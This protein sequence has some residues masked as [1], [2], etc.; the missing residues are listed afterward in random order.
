MEELLKNNSQ[1]KETKKR[2]IDYFSVFERDIE[3]KV[4]CIPS[5]KT[6]DPNHSEFPGAHVVGMFAF[7]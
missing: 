1:Y 2:L 4:I 5:I 7:H 3:S 6:N